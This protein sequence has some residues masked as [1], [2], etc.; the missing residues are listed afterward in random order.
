MPSNDRGPELAAV[1]GAFLGLA[2]ISVLL[3]CYVRLF[4]LKIFRPED[5]LAVWTLASFTSYAV[6]IILTIKYGGGKHTIDVPRENIPKVVQM[7]WAS[8]I[9]YVATITTL[10]LTVGLFLLRICSQLWHKITIGAVLVV[11]VLFNIGFFFLAVFQCRPVSYFW[12]HDTNPTAVGSCLSNEL[13]TSLTYAASGV[14]AAGDWFLALMPILLV[15][16]LE[17]GKR[18]KI[19][20]AGILALGTI[21]SA[22]TIVRIFYVWQ[23]TRGGD[24]LYQYTDFTIWSTVE[25]GLGLTASS[26]ATLRPLFKTFLNAASQYGFSQ[27]NA[28]RRPSMNH[29]QRYSSGPANGNHNY[30]IALYQMKSRPRSDE[31]DDKM[32]LSL[33]QYAWPSYRVYR[34]GRESHEGYTCPVSPGGTSA[35]DMY[36]TSPKETYAGGMYPTSPRYTRV[37]Y[38]SDG[39]QHYRSGEHWTLSQNTQGNGRE[40][41]GSRQYRS[42]EQWPLSDNMYGYG[43]ESSRRVRIQSV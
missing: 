13:I 17:L 31:I 12:L 19:S 39:S 11:C 3:R 28:A 26:V 9:T 38:H 6:F 20:I 2:A 23:L 33:D 7:R 15:Q 25:N 30:G 21:A 18:Q 36:P 37:R 1:T 34:P 16:N 42:G 27:A 40:S 35:G 24:V 8:E 5:W 29:S 4:M 32:P 10:K 41:S 43:V 22:A 14:N